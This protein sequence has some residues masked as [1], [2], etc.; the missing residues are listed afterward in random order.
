[1]SVKNLDTFL[2]AIEKIETLEP[3]IKV[4]DFVNPS[5]EFVSLSTEHKFS[6]LKKVITN[7]ENIRKSANI[8]EATK[9][10]IFESF[11]S[12]LEMLDNPKS[13]LEIS[14][15]TEKD[16]AIWNFEPIEKMTKFYRDAKFHM[17]FES[18]LS[19]EAYIAIERDVL[20]EMKRQLSAD[21][22]LFG[23]AKGLSKSPLVKSEKIASKLTMDSEEK[24]YHSKINAMFENNLDRIERLKNV[25]LAPRT[26]A[27]R[28]VAYL[29]M[30]EKALDDVHG[31][32]SA[33]PSNMRE[34]N[35]LNETRLFAMNDDLL[36]NLK[37]KIDDKRYKLLAN[38]ISARYD[39]VSDV[40]KQRDAEVAAIESRHE[41]GIA[42]KSLQIEKDIT[43][44]ISPT[45]RMGRMLEARNIV[46]KV[47][48]KKDKTETLEQEVGA[49]AAPV[50]VESEE[51]A[52][53]RFIDS[54]TKHIVDQ[55]NAGRE[56]EAIAQEERMR[57]FD[58]RLKRMEDAVL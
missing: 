56:A 25:I 4:V 12:Y 57:L 51:E 45:S 39:I 47:Q 33:F 35:N 49:D 46:E 21:E 19:D 15:G 54:L 30:L 42:A 31:L 27:D 1:M 37:G 26:S 10:Q 7:L 23:F 55:I 32:A 17:D 5:A 52:V 28:Q 50:V 9:M 53:N 6:Y 2:S 11:P 34:K 58:D 16:F 3:E 8:D 18:T 38:G 13:H 41:G 36:T 40:I 43:Q 48:D 20:A 22:A 24:I 44:F 14:E 29:S